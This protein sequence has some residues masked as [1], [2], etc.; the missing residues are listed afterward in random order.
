MN[1]LEGMRCMNAKLHLAMHELPLN[2]HGQ[3]ELITRHAMHEYLIATC[4]A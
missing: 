2:L 1:C 3:Y 4:Y